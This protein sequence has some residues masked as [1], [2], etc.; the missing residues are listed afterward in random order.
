MEELLRLA[1]KLVSLWSQE[2]VHPLASNLG[3]WGAN[4]IISYV[5]PTSGLDLI[6]V[7][8]VYSALPFYWYGGCCQS[9]NF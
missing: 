8:I 2:S 4:W 6:A 9:S 5:D 3:V 7:I 1:T